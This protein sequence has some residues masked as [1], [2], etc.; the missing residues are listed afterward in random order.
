M[1]RV[2]RATTVTK[3]M[4]TAVLIAA[5]CLAAAMVSCKIMRNATTPMRIIPMRV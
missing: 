3:L 5:P 4:M 2:K 1:D